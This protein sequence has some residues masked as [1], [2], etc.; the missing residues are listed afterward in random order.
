MLDVFA[1]MFFSR[2]PVAFYSTDNLIIA[3]IFLFFSLSV[4]C[5]QLWLFNGQIDDSTDDLFFRP[6]ISSEHGSPPFLT[7]RDRELQACVIS[8]SWPWCQV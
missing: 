4:V 2:R 5:E 6:V 1:Y 7:T 3:F 8:R